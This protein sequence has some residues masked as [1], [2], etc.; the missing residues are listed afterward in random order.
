V[1]AVRP[2]DLFSSRGKTGFLSAGARIRSRHVR[3]RTICLE[4]ISEN[5]RKLE[6]FG[7]HLTACNVPTLLLRCFIA[8]S[9]PTPIRDF[10]FACKLLISAPGSAALAVLP[11]A[12]AIAAC[13]TI[14]SVIYTVL[15]SAPNFTNPNGLV[16]VWESNPAQG[17]TK[18][19]V[20]PATFRDWRENSHSLAL[21]LVAPGSP[22]TIAAPG[23]PERANLQYATSGLFNLL[24]VHPVAGRFFGDPEESN[25]TAAV[26]LSYSLW[27]RR[28]RGNPAAIGEKVVVNGEVHTISGV[29]PPDFHLFDMD[30]DIWMPIASPDA[31]SQDRS[32]RGWLIAVG[33][34]KRGETLASAQAEM[35]ML[36]RR[37]AAAHPATNQNWTARVETIQEAQFGTWKGV[38]YPLWGAVT[39]VLII[40]CANSAICFLDAS[41]RGPGKFRFV[42]HLARAV[43]G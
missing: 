17:I 14:F 1:A 36:T 32:F 33:R 42:P 37:I 40:S 12:L 29:L 31:H 2:D 13:T 26:I 3:N 41:R 16:A 38:L 15:L 22:V 24:G 8:I 5:S 27:L 21:E 20:A 34:L 9:A 10:W 7:E 23:L 6:I 4:R 25:A 11:L 30:T 19:P 35:G 18:S 43:Q 28:F 39:F